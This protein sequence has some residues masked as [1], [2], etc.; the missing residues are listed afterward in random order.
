[1][2]DLLETYYKDFFENLKPDIY[3]I[4]PEEIKLT[5]SNVK[6][7]ADTF[8]WYKKNPWYQLLWNI[9]ILN[10][11]KTYIIIT[12]RDTY[13]IE[14]NIFSINYFKD[15]L[16]NEMFVTDVKTEFY[17]TFLIMKYIYRMKKI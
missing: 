11:Q 13:N 2:S 7:L 14:R 6:K 10:Y 17:I 4:T 1:M 9:E 3:I 8:Q 5:I 12:D 16:Y 15:Q